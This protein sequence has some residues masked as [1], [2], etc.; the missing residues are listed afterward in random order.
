LNSFS[1]SEK[2]ENQDP[3]PSGS[4]APTVSDF[5]ERLTPATGWWQR[6]LLFCASGW[7]EEH[8]AA[9]DSHRSRLALL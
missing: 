5:T 8:H 6:S 3:P 1:H 4:G 9:N 2:L 7:N